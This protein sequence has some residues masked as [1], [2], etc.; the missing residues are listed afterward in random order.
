MTTR[1]IECSKFPHNV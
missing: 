1:N